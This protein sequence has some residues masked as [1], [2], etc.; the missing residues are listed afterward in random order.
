VMHRSSLRCRR[1]GR[2]AFGITHGDRG[3]FDEIK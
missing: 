3:D 1:T 2:S